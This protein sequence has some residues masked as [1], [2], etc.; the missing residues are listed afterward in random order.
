[1]E[2]ETAESYVLDRFDPIMNEM[3]KKKVLLDF[4][5]VNVNGDEVWGHLPLMALMSDVILETAMFKREERLLLKNINAESLEHVVNYMYTAEVD[6]T[7]DNVLMI[8]GAATH[9]ELEHLQSL[10]WDFLANNSNR[11]EEDIIR[12]D[13]IHKAWS[14]VE[15]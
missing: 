9:L 2:D 11:N 5:L 10:C 15:V 3:R 12:R 13:I 4:A 1:M 8:L 14:I 6:L 7:R